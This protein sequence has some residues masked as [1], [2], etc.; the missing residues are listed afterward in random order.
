[1]V[2]N[3]VTAVTVTPGCSKV[4]D[5]YNQGHHLLPSALTG[6]SFCILLDFSDTQELARLDHDKAKNIALMCAAA[7]SVLL[8]FKLQLGEAA[9]AVRLLVSF[10]PSLL[11]LSLF[12]YVF[13]INTPQKYLFCDSMLHFNDKS[14]VF[15]TD[16]KS[17]CKTRSF[18]TH[19]R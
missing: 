16:A 15:R 4:A 11:S 13:P 2:K 1:M 8:G 7:C 3:C 18:S 17:F 5:I 6:R 10:G 19:R 12:S 9:L 14:I